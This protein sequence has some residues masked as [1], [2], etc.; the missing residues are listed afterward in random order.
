MK[1][2]K[3][4]VW[5]VGFGLFIATNVVVAATPAGDPFRELWN[6]ITSLQSQITNIQLTPGPT[7]PQGEKGDKGDPGLPSWDEKRILALED[8]VHALENPLE[9]PPIPCN[10]LTDNFNSYT[11][12]PIIGQGGWN[13][14][15]NGISF[16]I[17][18]TFVKE[19]NN[20]LRNDNV[21]N[22]SI[23]TNKGNACANG[24]QSFYLY[25]ENRWAWVTKNIGENVQ[26]GVFDGSWDS[27][28]KATMAFK[29]DGKVSYFDASINQ[30]LDLGTYPDNSWT[31]AEIEWRSIDKTARY[32]L[33]DSAWTEWTPI[34]TGSDYTH[35]DTFGIGLSQLSGGGV[36]IDDLR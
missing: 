36:D 26:I 7:G 23:I 25:T 8:R 1:L 22:N 29:K 3:K 16:E 20:A 24:S 15:E 10:I 32:R 19:G 17:S 27:T 18:H 12:G 34:I 31:K 28:A 14:I 5:L 2:N 11:G 4:F 21:L 33:N 30:Y 13:N 35:F 9:P 6:A